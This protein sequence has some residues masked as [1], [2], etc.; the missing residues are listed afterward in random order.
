MA[1]ANHHPVEGEVKETTLS[2]SPHVQ[3]R[4]V[5]RIN[6]FKNRGKSGERNIRVVG[7]VV[8]TDIALGVYGVL[9]DVKYKLR[10]IA[11]RQPVKVDDVLILSPSV[12]AASY[13]D[14][15]SDDE[16][17]SPREK[18]QKNS[19]GFSDFCVKNISQAAFGRREI[20]IAEQEMPGIMALRKRAE[21][22]KPLQ[23]AKIVGCTHINAQTAVLIETLVALGASVRWAPCNIY[24]T[25]NEVAAA[26]AE[27]DISVFAWKGES[28]DD[29]WWCIDRC[30]HSENWQPN[31]ILDDGG[32]ATHLML[33]KYPAMFKLIKGIVEESVTGV[34]RLYQLSKSGRL[35]VPA[36]NVNDSV[37]KTKFDNL[38]S[39]RE[40]ILDALKRSTDVMFGGKQVLVCGYGEVGKGC[41]SALKGMG[42]IVYVTEIDPICAL[43]ACMD[44]FRVVKINEVVRN[45]DILITATGNKNV[46][47]REHMD[48]MKNSCI[49]CNMG[50]SNT[51][52]DVQSLRTPE[53]TW[54][55]VRSQVDHIIWPDG[56]RI[57]LLA[58]GRLVNLSCSSIPSFVVSI[59][60]ATQ[61]L[62][63]IEL[64]NAPHGRY[65]S[66]VY[67]LPKKMDEYVA[68]LH[69]PTF[70]AHLTELTDDQAK[71]MGLNKAGPFKPNYY[72][73]RHCSRLKHPNKNR[74]R[75][76]QRCEKAISAI[77]V[78]N[79]ERHGFKRSKASER[80]RSLNDRPGG[81]GYQPYAANHP[82]EDDEATGTSSSSSSSRPAMKSL[83]DSFVSGGNLDEDDPK[84]L[85][86]PRDSAPE[87]PRQKNTLYVHGAGV[88]EDLLRGA[89]SPFGALL[90]ISME[91][92][93]NPSSI[94]LASRCE[95]FLP[96][97][98]VPAAL[99]IRRP[100][101]R[102]ACVSRRHLERPR[103]L[104]AAMV[105]VEREKWSNKIEF[106]LSTVGLSVGLGNVWRFPYV[107]F[108]NG[109]GAFMVPYI[110][111]M[112]VLGRPMYYME[113]VLGQFASDAQ[114]RSFGGFPLAKG[115]GWAMVYA[116]AFISLYYNVL[117]GYALLYLVYSFRETL[118]WTT[119]D[120]SEWANSDCYN[121]APGVVSRWPR[122]DFYADLPIVILVVQYP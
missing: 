24:S 76:K 71:Y 119:C 39:C 90:N 122:R 67:L 9:G 20:E 99:R 95:A 98:T 72:R 46:V 70:D 73:K 47:Q 51:E 37:T 117:L 103:N 61:A 11:S 77:K 120:Y 21:Q 31:M 65:K 100:K 88:S 32:D 83:Y 69:L 93:K 87:K 1:S 60:A 5:D 42:A 86:S 106:I 44:G 59:T 107:A 102:T 82:T 114:T 84:H 45:I 75:S 118:P 113:L 4:R 56:K 62:A 81:I 33:K 80:K 25:Q 54:E 68:S 3:R 97:A 40:S 101:T 79:K 30:V 28:E 29:F 115:V 92:D 116:C 96:S 108:E 6:T 104:T 109:G 85:E 7:T 53:L 38:Y 15:S 8:L 35:T 43:Q 27:A 105:G 52:I 64:Y 34:H 22:D 2:S 19:K 89:F 78:E 66:D 13:T 58:E 63:L 26:L 17:V 41:C 112:I 121:P 48:K 110:V 49:V 50:H 111:L 18:V 16:G 23:G 57:V 10:T 14:T 94:V 74:R 36:M 55:K 91:L 12:C